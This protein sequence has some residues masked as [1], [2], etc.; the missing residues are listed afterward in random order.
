DDHNQQTVAIRVQDDG[1]GMSPEMQQRIFDRFQRGD[2]S[3]STPGFG[4]GLSIARAL[5]EAQQGSI[6]VDSDLGKGS[7][8]TI[9]LPKAA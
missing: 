8:F 4:L 3:R 1:P 9:A 2:T 7:A 6:A 5:I